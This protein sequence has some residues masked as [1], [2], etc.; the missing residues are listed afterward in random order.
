[1]GNMREESSMTMQVV[2][3]NATVNVTQDTTTI[4][5]LAEKQIIVY[6][7]QSMGNETKKQCEIQ[8]LPPN[9]P[10]PEAAAQTFKLMVMPLL[11]SNAVCGGND[12]TYDTW[13]F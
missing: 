6:I 5:N 1:M 12:G 10:D 11:Q 3:E 9:T 4:L 2:V 8:A 7:S 13:K